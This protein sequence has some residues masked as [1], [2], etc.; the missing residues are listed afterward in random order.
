MGAPKK[1]RNAL[2]DGLYARH[3]SPSQ[4]SSL[5]KMSPRESEPEIAAIGRAQIQVEVNKANV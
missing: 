1:N 5:G 4:V 3:Y 2:K